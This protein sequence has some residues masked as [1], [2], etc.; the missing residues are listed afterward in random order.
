MDIDSKQ[1][2]EEVYSVFG[3]KGGWVSGT[4]Y[5]ML[6]VCPF[7]NEEYTFHFYGMTGVWA[8][9]ACHSHGVDVDTLKSELL[10]KT[11]TG[12][13]YADALEMMRPAEAPLGIINLGAHYEAKVIDDSIPTGFG[14]IDMR[15][16]GLGK[17]MYT[18][19]AGK[20][21]SGKSTFASQLALN[22][23]NN[24]I[25]TCFYSGELNTKTF[26]QWTMLQAS[27]NQWLKAYTNKYGA[28]KYEIADSDTENMIRNW[29]LN[30]MF[31]YD[32]SVI[33]S[34]QKD[35][36]FSRFRQAYKFYGCELFFI[37][38]L[39]SARYDRS[40]GSDKYEQ[41]VDFV[42]SVKEFVNEL[43]VHVVLVAHCKKEDTGD[44][45]DNVAGASEVT[46]FA[47]NVLTVERIDEE[48]KK[49]MTSPCDS[50]VVCSKNR[51]EGYMGKFG[52]DFE[53]SSKRLIP[54]D[55]NY[56]DKYGWQDAF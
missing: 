52:F 26:Q 24:G 4:Q 19:L 11:T 12:R 18:V 25:K 7:C 1:R 45:N 41:Q 51:G 40:M 15:I 21:G 36:L 47:D 17:G 5:Y 55:L 28:T 34:S 38:N 6:P 31:L 20:R 13:L 56:I 33:M 44:Y 37:D 9:N 39:M 43:N 54:I 48:K 42:R 22:A 8:C 14:K 2:A 10:L 53:S 49:K 16:G 3:G 35:S 29:L 27:G 23:V 50:V 32:N 46:N 30:K